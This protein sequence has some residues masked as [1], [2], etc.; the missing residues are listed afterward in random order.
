MAY[1]LLFLAVLVLGATALLVFGR[2]RAAAAAG[3]GLDEA[4]TSLPPVFLPERPREADIRAVRFSLGFRGY[5]CDQVDDVL[6][7]LSGEIERLNACLESE[8]NRCD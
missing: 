6:D 8:R 4:P 1:A 3:A 2:G 5:R 7:A